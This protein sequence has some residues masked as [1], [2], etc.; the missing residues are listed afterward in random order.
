MLKT[1]CIIPARGGSKGV[2]RKNIRKIAG[3]PLLGYVIENL[4][5]GKNFSNIIVST[6]DKEIAKIAKKYGAEVPF[7]RPKKLASDT[8]PMDEVLL[9]AVKKLKKLNY[10]FNTFVWR[11]A[12]TP[13]ITNNDIKKSINLLKKNKVAIVCGVYKQHLNPY[14][15]IVEKD[16]KGNLKLVKPLKNKARSRQEAP[17]VYQLNGLY[18]YDT[19]KF[20][21]IKKT[22]LS[23]SIHHEIPIET[24]L[25]IDTEFEFKIA[26]LIIQNEN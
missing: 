19:E 2:P 23:K 20:L 6:E 9:H 8:T 22:D 11:D 13:F 1:I 25:M 10:D 12:T 15:N 17:I 3:K 7:L 21:K 24:G 16:S 4:K 14:Y 5:K 18:V 26:E